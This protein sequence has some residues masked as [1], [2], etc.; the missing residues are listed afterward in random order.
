MK[1][2][3][4]LLAAFLLIS[5]FC[6][7]QDLTK[8][9]TLVVKDKSLKEVLKTISEK[10][11]ILFSYNPQEIPV[12]TRITANMQD[13]TI[14]EVLDGILIK[15]G[16]DY[17]LLDKQVVLKKQMLPD[18]TAAPKT[19]QEIKN[20]TVSGYLRERSTGEILIGANVFVKGTQVGTTTNAYGFYSLTLPA[21]DYLLAFSFIGYK[22]E[23]REIMLDA[24]QAFSLELEGTSL[25]IKEVEVVG[26]ETESDNRGFHFSEI[27]LTPKVLS[28]LPG[29]V[30]DVD[31]IKALQVIPGFESYGDGSALFYVR[32]GKSDQNLVQID[33]APIYN[34]SHLFGFMSAL[35]PDAINDVQAWKGDFPLN[36]G[37]RLSSVIDIKSKDGNMK[38][39]GIAGNFGPYAS[40]LSVEG[41]IIKNKSSFFISGRK[42]T[43]GWLRLF[44]STLKPFDITFFDVN[45]K[46]NLILNDRNRFY[47]SFYWGEDMLNRNT[48]EALQTYGISWNNILGTARWNHVFSPKLF[49]NTTFY[50]SQY[51]YYLFTSKE[52]KDYWNSSIAHASLKSDF[53]W[54][55]NPKNTLRAGLE[56]GY[57]FFNPGNVRI[58]DTAVQN[59]APVVSKYHSMEYVFYV[60]NDQK[61]G[62]KISIRYGLRIPVWQDFGPTT[63]YYFNTL[64]QVSD[65]MV[66]GNNKAYATFVRPEPRFHIQYTFNDLSAIKASYCRTT[67]FIQVLSNST[68]PFTSLEVWAPSG[69][70]IRPQQADQ[71]ALG[72]YRRIGWSG[73][74]F[75]AE[76]FY[77]YFYNNIDYTDHANMLYNPLIEGQLRFGDAWSY[78]LEVMLRKPE[79]KLTG[80]IGY[81]YSRAFVKTNE[82]NSGKTYPA[83]YDRPHDICVN[84]AYNTEKHW[85][86]S[87]NW[88]LLS[89]SAITTPVSFYYYNGYSVPVYGSKNNDRLP[90]YHRLD[91]SVTYTISKPAD[92]FQHSVVLTLYNAY[93]HYNPFSVNFN[94]M[95]TSGG[96]FVLPSSMNGSYELVPT[97]MSVAGIIPSV[98]Y[99]FRF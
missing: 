6:S 24:D 30:G 53:T 55:L 40:N 93:G 74:N 42:S 91:L 62:R 37:D 86:F 28:Q 14:K 84:L 75:S 46:F 36:Y 12:E 81:T 60:S 20:H 83:F 68:S 98:N 73:L 94:K 23:F 96:D 80:W 67:Q 16:I 26:R 41:P 34:P 95:E 27:K 59:N 72:Y 25:E 64:H 66:V 49:S 50:Y 48:N 2:R 44:S 38:R 85:A 82:V 29:F 65:T 32:G 43:L 51:N 13:R 52:L 7:A 97:T 92:R 79:G 71:V 21:G 61:I 4:L 10:G 8:K 3:I 56:A 1:Y 89:G 99:I 54:Y 15:N 39:F 58:T 5:R 77:K 57:H 76:A 45:A 69:P 19:V 9:I 47:I 88:I 35:S 11:T 70:N 63:V 78:G 87:A 33:E 22:P 90:A 31:V 18:H 17:F